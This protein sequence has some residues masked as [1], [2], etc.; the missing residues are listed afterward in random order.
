MLFRHEGVG[1]FC[2]VLTHAI[3]MISQSG[4]DSL[5]DYDIYNGYH[6]VERILML[7]T[8]I[9]DFWVR[10]VVVHYGRATGVVS[11]ILRCYLVS[12]FECVLFTCLSG[13]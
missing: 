1:S 9:Y 13:C 12:M 8:T 11:R 6:L 2:I 3:P 10:H 5:D 4:T 7:Q